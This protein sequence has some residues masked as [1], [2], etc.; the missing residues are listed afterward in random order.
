ML[1]ELIAVVA[2]GFMGGGV[3][4]VARRVAKG[5]PRWTVPFAAGGAMM[6][7]AVSLE[8]SWF[9]R[10]AQSLP[11]GVEVAL[12]HESRAPWRPWTYVAPF[13][14]RFIAVDRASVRTHEAAPDLRMV[15]LVAFARW[16]APQRLG[17][18]L[19]CEDGRRADLVPGVTFGEDGRIEGATW[20]EM[21]PDHPVTRIAC[22][23]A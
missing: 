6:I 4:S 9:S 16:S 19:D 20:H 7:V 10:T 3:A 15:D 17:V 1:F 22:A 21:G 12:T 18:V 23:A 13:V 5:L 8:Y 14:D 2:A 11:D